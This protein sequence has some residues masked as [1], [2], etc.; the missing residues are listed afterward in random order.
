[1]SNE[2]QR[3]SDNIKTLIDS[4]VGKRTDKGGEIFND[5]ENNQANAPY[6]TSRGNKTVAGGKGFLIKS[7]TQVPENTLGTVRCIIKL[8]STEGLATGDVVSANI[9][10]NFAD[11]A[12]IVS[13]EN[14][15]IN[16]DAYPF[17]SESCVLNDGS[18][19]LWVNEKPLIGTHVLGFGQ[20][21]DGVESIA[22]HVGAS[23]RG[24]YNVSSGKYADT[25]GIGNVA[26]YAGH[27]QNKENKALGLC[28]SASGWLNEAHGQSS[29]VGGQHSKTVANCTFSRGDFNTVGTRAFEVESMEFE[30]VPEV[31]EEITGKTLTVYVSAD[32]LSTADGTDITNP[33]PSIGSAIDFCAAAGTLST[34][35]DVLYLILLDNVDWVCPS[36]SHSFK[37]VVQPVD[38]VQKTVTMTKSD[39]FKGPMEFKNILFTGGNKNLCFN[40]NDVIFDEDSVL[41]VY[42]VSYGVGAANI[43]CAGQTVTL[44][45]YC[46]AFALYPKNSYG[47]LTYT[48]DV[49]TI[50]DSGSVCTFYIGDANGTSVFNKNLNFDFRTVSK[51]EFKNL[52]KSYY[53][54]E[55]AVQIINSSLIPLTIDTE[56]LNYINNS[57]KWILTNISGCKDALSFTEET[58]KFK[59]KSGYIARAWSIKDELTE[60]EEGILDLSGAAGEYT[61]EIEEEQTY[62]GVIKLN[63]V[64]GLEQNDVVSIKKAAGSEFLLNLGSITEVLPENSIIK[65]QGYPSQIKRFLNVSTLLF[66]LEKPLVGTKIIGAGGSTLGVSNKVIGRAAT[67]AGEGLIAMG[68]NQAVYGFYNKNKPDTVLE[69]G[70]GEAPVKDGS[71]NITKEAVR[72][73]VFEVYKDGSVRLYD[74]KISRERWLRLLEKSLEEVYTKDYIDKNYYTADVI[75]ENVY[76]KSDID[77]VFATKDYVDSKI[78]ISDEQPE[79]VEG[80]IWIK[81]LV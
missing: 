63:S 71:G 49:T 80:T 67:A 54:L 18:A 17:P 9:S 56:G 55:G 39:S 32:G 5:Y 40:G 74:I 68:D 43:E 14:T 6:S 53:T 59:V 3:L 33:A 48:E 72:N 26:G 13:I 62:P 30:D 11:F 4:H 15:T 38:T 51:I 79:V 78:V 34:A 73:N 75:D 44:K 21:A 28:T 2:L 57:K 22:I 23:T 69:V 16:L 1:M 8:N 64:V 24:V 61:F 36:N 65:V 19:F 60:S 29:D 27:A 45:G 46:S 81:P 52:D 66:V 20:S 25:S 41:S 50:A 77:A 31:P 47:K 58:G 76:I 12:R 35:N 42:Y 37:V 10:G 70:C 7:I